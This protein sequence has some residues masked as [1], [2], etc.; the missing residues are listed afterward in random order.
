MKTSKIKYI[1]T[2]VILKSLNEAPVRTWNL[3]PTPA[4]QHP[5]NPTDE[6][7]QYNK[8]KAWG[9]KD[10]LS[11]T[12]REL[13]KY[14]PAFAKGYKEVQSDS[15]WNKFNAKLTDMIARLGNSVGK[16]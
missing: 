11:G 13:D 3:D 5:P 9:V 14:P 2:E 15:W 7:G 10:R 6:V 1:I 4:G 8:G 12:Q 16:R